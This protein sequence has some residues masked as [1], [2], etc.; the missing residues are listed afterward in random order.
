MKNAMQTVGTLVVLVM[1]A[2][3]AIVLMVGMVDPACGPDGDSQR[4]C[5]AEINDD[6]LNLVTKAVR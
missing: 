5:I 3:L 1:M 2:Y 4:A 6:L